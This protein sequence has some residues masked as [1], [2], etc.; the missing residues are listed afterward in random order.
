MSNMS[1][2][3]IRQRSQGTTNKHKDGRRDGLTDGETE[4]RK[5]GGRDG[6]GIKSQSK[7]EETGV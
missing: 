7:E 6:A 2:S 3:L 5:E 4:G 1:E